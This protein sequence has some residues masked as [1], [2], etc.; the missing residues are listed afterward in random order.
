MH[1]NYSED[2]QYTPH[3]LI[4]MG[5]EKGM[6]IMA[7]SD[8]NTI[9]GVKEMIEAG[10]AEDIQI[11]PAIECS[12]VYRGMDVHLLGYGIDINYPYFVQLPDLLKKNSYTQFL[13]RCDKMNE[14][15]GLSLDG[16]KLW[17]E[18][19]GKAAWFTLCQAAFHDPKAKDIED[20]QDYLPGGKRCNPAPV[21]FYWDK[22]QEGSPLRIPST[23]PTLEDSIRE[24]HNAGGLAFIA[25]P[26]NNFDH[27]EDYLQEVIDM[28]ID[29]IEAYSNYHTEKQNEFYEQYC[30]DHHLLISCGSDFHG[31]KK[32][33]IIMGE[34]GLKKD[35]STYIKDICRKL[36]LKDIK[37][38][39][40]DIDGTLYNWSRTLTNETI[41]VINK[42]HEQGIE[43]G[44]A[45]GRPYEELV[46]YA[47]SWGFDYQFDAI[48]GLN[49]AEVWDCH[50]NINHEYYQL[51]TDLLKEIIE[52]MSQFTCNPFMYWNQKLLCI[53]HDAM[54]TKSAK[55][56]QR[57]VV[58]AKDISELYAQP[59]AKIMF[60][61]EESEVKKVE[62]YLEAHPSNEYVGF[63]T[64]S[65]L[66][67]F[68]DPRISKG[69]GID[70]YCEITG[71][72]PNQILSFGDTT[73]DN[74]MLE[75]CGWSVCLIDGT[76]DTKAISKD[77]TEYSC[78]DSG[79]AR[80]M[81]KYFFK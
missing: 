55:T 3:E 11:I 28:G 23:N 42:L 73:N 40:C 59:N 54:I 24:I 56:S 69:F 68:M 70:K 34:Y 49:G 9:I 36:A 4:Q 71:I 32:P 46:K 45:S 81:N 67:E 6:K 25:H 19:D 8:H 51:S 64:Q 17:K 74:S 10:K 72:Q 5:K 35:G 52:L 15:Y 37:V 16:E 63:K 65:T 57:E 77:I 53:N 22:C 66:I 62:K 44:L 27:K 18:C 78:A 26:F 75:R 29:G 2:G 21:N 76:D 43:F 20:F 50:S 1:S 48:I 58:V 61:M 38:V 80:Y 41:E 12:T 7:L 31:N 33:S 14:V 47:E 79:F 30:L 39:L 60:R 13:K